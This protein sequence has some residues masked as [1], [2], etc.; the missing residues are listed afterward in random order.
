MIK[1]Y[2]DLEVWQLAMDATQSVYRLIHTFPQEERFVLSQQ[3][4]RAMLSVP[5]NIA[6]GHSRGS[7]REFGR[8]LNIAMGSL[9]EVE[10]CLVLATRFGYIYS[11]DLELAECLDALGRKLRILQ[12]SVYAQLD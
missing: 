11:K 9:A 12:K 6:E 1:S 5:L 8:F 4:R 3:L 2:Q 7:Q 10:T